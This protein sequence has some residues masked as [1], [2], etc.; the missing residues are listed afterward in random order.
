MDRVLKA[1]LTV[2]KAALG[3]IFRKNLIDTVANSTKGITYI[4]GGAGFG[5]TTLLSQLAGS[6]E[7]PVWLTLD[8]EDSAIA[9]ANVLGEAIRSR[10]PDFSFH[11]SEYMIFESR[12]DYAATLANALISDMENIPEGFIIILDDLH[13]LKSPEAK[14]L[15]TFLSK[16]RPQM[17]R[18]FLSSREVLWDELIPE[19]IKGNILEL[20]QE[21]LKFSR[22]EVNQIL[23][24]DDERIYNLTEGWPIA[25]GSFRL[26]LESGVSLA[27]MPA[28]RN[29]LLYSYLF[30]ECVEHLPIETVSFLKATACFEEL[31]PQM[32]SAILGMKNTKLILEGLVSRNIFTA[33]ASSGQYRYH[34]LFREYLQEGL[35]DTAR[36]SLFDLATLYYMDLKQYS[37]A[38][39]Y[40]MQAEN[41]KNLEQIILISYKDCIRGGNF[42]ELRSWFHALGDTAVSLSK[43]LLVAKAAFLSSIGNFAEASI[44]LDRALPLINEAD[45]ELYIEA[46]V[47]KARVLRNW[48]S[49]EESNKLL[50]KL[51]ARLRQPTS[52][53]YYTVIIEKIYNLCWNSQTNEAYALT[54]HMIE[55][56]AGSGNLRVKAW[57]ERY[58]SVVHFLAGRM[59]EAVYFYEKSLKI[60]EDERQYLDMHCIDIYIAKA[61]QMMGE[62]DK[63]VSMVTEELQKLRNAGRYE[64][65]WLGYLFAAEIHYQNTSIDRAN[66]ISPSYQTTMKYFSLADEYAPLYRKTQFQKNW[67]KMQYNIYILIMNREPKQAVIDDIFDNLDQV[68]D[69]FKTIAL[70]RLMNYFGSISDFNSAL[71]CAKM[72]IEIG[73]RTNMMLMATG[74]YGMLARATIAMEDHDKAVSVTSRYLQL[75]DKNGFY[76]YFRMRKAYD[77]ILEFALDNGIEPDFTEQMMVFAGYKIKKAYITTLGGF[78]ISPCKDRENP[79]KMRTKKAREFL[80]FLID[81][82][83]EGVTME[84]II[85]ALWFDSESVN[86]IKLVSVYLA[87][88]RKDLS[89]LGIQNPVRFS[90]RHYRVCGDEL[91]VDTDEFESAISGFKQFKDLERAQK[92]VSLYRGEYMAGYEALWAMAKRIRYQ[93]VYEE[94]LLYCKKDARIGSAPNFV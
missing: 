19:Y 45:Q 36:L 27:D 30:Y 41:K 86:I 57:Y 83:S 94:A 42:D 18:L 89:F 50:D 90:V 66:G 39:R 54:N 6:F 62:R 37:K 51:A 23:E 24:L 15:I 1:R 80:A 69:Y 87:Q 75:C 3:E 33:R 65:L 88:I 73:E 2:P 70:A 29:K 48:I 25:I 59:K 53:L 32:L 5:K 91:T 56:C 20:T 60:P 64:E 61:Y 8:G 26:L 13:T 14:S 4:H 92:V 85:E 38:A 22:Y 7:N 55:A 52:E 10:F 9:L 74:A 44:C 68:G 46:M 67:A 81:A 28:W 31:D 47:H 40:A 11:A 77:P 12:D 79:L 71:K 16:Y 63:A 21:D 58:F 35:E 78:S 76:E 43:E 82:G 72:C 17:L 34:A 49:F 84:R 93:K